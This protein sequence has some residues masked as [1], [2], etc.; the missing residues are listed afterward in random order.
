MDGAHDLLLLGE[1][2]RSDGK[3]SFRSVIMDFLGNGCGWWAWKFGEDD[4]TLILP[5]GRLVHA[6]YNYLLEW[7]KKN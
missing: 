4:R 3:L 5:Y 1:Y 2:Q 7:P 6:G